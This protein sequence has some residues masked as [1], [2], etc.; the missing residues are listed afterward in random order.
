M[1]NGFKFKIKSNQYFQGKLNE[2][3]LIKTIY[4]KVKQKF[5]R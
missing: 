3:Y 4:R 1:I 2:K 5:Y